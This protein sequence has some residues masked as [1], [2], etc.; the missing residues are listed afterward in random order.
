MLYLA[1]KMADALH[2]INPVRAHHLNQG[3]GI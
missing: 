2:A 3:V 1:A